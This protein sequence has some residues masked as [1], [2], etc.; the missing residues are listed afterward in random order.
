M[1]ASCVM[2]AYYPKCRYWL[3][4]INADAFCYVNHSLGELLYS[5]TLTYNLRAPFGA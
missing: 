3:K 2:E 5:G 4:Y 1:A